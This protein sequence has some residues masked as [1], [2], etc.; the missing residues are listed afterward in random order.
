MQRLR[1]DRP[2]GKGGRS[3]PRPG[4]VHRKSR[5][6][7]S[8][9]IAQR[10]RPVVPH[11]LPGSAQS[12][13]SLEQ[14]GQAPRHQSTPLHGGVR[15]LPRSLIEIAQQEDGSTGVQELRS[16][17]VQ[18]FWS[19]GVQ[20]FRSNGVMEWGSG[21]V[22]EWWRGGVVELWWWRCLSVW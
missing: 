18:A 2:T 7:D 9:R 4:L 11:S 14:T 3:P 5:K 1:G 21:G 16:S 6:I 17:G 15:F 13:A 22:V 12:A 19:S 8:K 10:A 20:E